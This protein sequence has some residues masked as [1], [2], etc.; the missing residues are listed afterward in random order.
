MVFVLDTNRQPLDPWTGVATP[1][2]FGTKIRGNF[3]VEVT[4]PMRMQSPAGFDQ[5]IGFCF[6]SFTLT[7][8]AATFPDL[9]SSQ[10]LGILAGQNMMTGRARVTGGPVVCGKGGG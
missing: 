1:G 2:S 9:A 8:T 7:S 4:E 10:S 5:S 3:L 6:A